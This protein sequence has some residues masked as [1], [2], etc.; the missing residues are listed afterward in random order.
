MSSISIRSKRR[1]SDSLGRITHEGGEI[2]CDVRDI[3]IAGA[4]LT[5]HGEQ[6]APES[7]SLKIEGTGLTFSCDVVWRKQRDLGVRFLAKGARGHAGAGS[8]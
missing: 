4:R 3:S 2:L 1:A 8:S 5:V 6:Q 7:F